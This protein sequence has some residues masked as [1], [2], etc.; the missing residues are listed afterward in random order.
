MI[1]AKVGK[2]T[3]ITSPNISYR[4]NEYLTQFHR[5]NDPQLSGEAGLPAVWG[6]VFFFTKK[7]GRGE[8][9]KNSGKGDI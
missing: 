5:Q 4:E 1:F 6:F 8:T 3:N 2:R 9:A 7:G